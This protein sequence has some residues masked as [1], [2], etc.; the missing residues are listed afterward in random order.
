MIKKWLA[1][2]PKKALPKEC[3]I[4]TGGELARRDAEF[5]L[6]RIREETAYY[7]RLGRDLH[8]LRERNHFA[9]NIRATMRR[10]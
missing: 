1:L 3:D 5:N 4:D 6:R 9:E 7:E 8:E 2:W 10:A